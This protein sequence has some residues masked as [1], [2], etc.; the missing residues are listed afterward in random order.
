MPYTNTWYAGWEGGSAKVTSDALVSS[1]AVFYT[2]NADTLFGDYALVVDGITA[3][4]HTYRI[5]CA[6][7]EVYVWAWQKGGSLRYEVVL[8]DGSILDL[9]WDSGHFDAHVDGGQVAEGAVLVS[10]TEWVNIQFHVSIANVGGLFESVI[11]GISDIAYTGD[12]Q[13][14]AL[15]TIGSI[16][17]K[18]TG[19]ITILIDCFGF[20]TGGWPGDLRVSPPILP[21]SDEAV[22]WT[23]S[24]GVDN[25][26]VVDEVP[27]GEADYVSS[28]VSGQK[29]KY[30]LTDWD[31]THKTPLAVQVW[32]RARKDVAAAHQVKLLMDDGTESASPARDLLTSWTYVSYILESPPGGGVWQDADI[33]ALL[34][35]QESVVV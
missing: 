7:S 14:G 5:L 11:D 13:P 8:T 25:Y 20:G 10:T 3:Q 6:G 26:A 33:D 31:D 2:S 30:G 18:V 17:F 1:W 28:A 12:T 9:R 4:T 22:T 29:D 21:Q 32:G 16:G 27:L 15:N 24:V 23:P 35:G 19:N 34:A